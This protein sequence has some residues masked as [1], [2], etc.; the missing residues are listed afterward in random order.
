M[1][2]LVTGATGFIGEHVVDLLLKEGFGVIGTARSLEKAQKVHAQFNNNP[3]VSFEIVPELTALDA[4]DNLFRERGESIQSVI[5]MASP[6]ISGATNFENQLLVPARNGT[7]AIFN[8]IKRYGKKV[9]RVVFTS[10]LL[11]LAEGRKLGDRTFTFNEGNW[12][13]VTWETCQSDPMNAYGGSKKFAEQAA[14]EFVESHRDEIN[15][16]L[17][18]VI[19]A[20]VLGPH[21]FAED[22]KDHLSLSNKII[23][24]LLN[25]SPDQTSLPKMHASFIDVRDV[26]RAHLI[27]LQKESATDQRICVFK[28]TFGSQDILDIL[29]ARFPEL[30]GKI[31]SGPNPGKGDQTP[32]CSYD[33]SFS[34]E[35]LGFEFKTLEESVYDTVEQVLSVR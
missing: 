22:V 12:S 8:A 6:F 30:R 2:V 17:T 19:P 24:G 25:S 33:S 35:I 23:D 34:D 32:S 10:S 21:K 3:K 29:N 28:S 7:I 31:S 18:A 5:H 15:F 13:S 20:M 9:R 26:A 16:K 14:W 27:A 4:F 11:A 1:S